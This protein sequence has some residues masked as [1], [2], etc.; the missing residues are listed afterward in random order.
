MD[1]KK[2]VNGIVDRHNT[3]D[4]FRIAAENNIYI[5]YEELGKNLGY[6]SNLFRI[7]TIRINDH[8]DPFLQPFICAHELGHALLHPHAGTH[9]FNRNSFIANCKIEKEANQFAVELLFPDGLMSSHP[10]TDIY[11]LARTAGIPHQL[12]YLKSI[13]YGTRRL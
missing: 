8:A 2:L 10:E 7:K 1:I 4:P 11:N 12:V 13:S 3:R 5:L 6:F 9:A